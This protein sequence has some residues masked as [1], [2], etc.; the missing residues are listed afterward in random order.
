MIAIGTHFYPAD[1]DSE[2]RQ[3]RARAALLALDGAIP[4]NLQFT[5][6]G[7]RP[8]GF[9]TLPVLRQDSRTVT[10]A[11]GVRKP[12]VSE[13]FAA[14]ADAARAGGCRYFAY[15]NADIEV[16]QAALET[17]LSGDRDAY[18]F[19]RVDL[20]PASGAELGV[21]LFGLDMFAVDAG[22]WAREARRFRPYI[23]G[24][25]CWD[26]VYAALICAHGR[27]H[28]VNEKPGI[29]H[30]RHPM[31]WKD[32]PFAEH[33]GFLAAL[34]APYFSRWCR[35]AAGLDEARKAGVTVDRRRLAAE[36][37][38]EARLSAGETVR[39]AARQMR[40]RFRHARR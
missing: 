15:L 16:R 3:A 29:Y 11:G 21:E 4:I 5:D 27:G 2:R 13:M 17:V 7:Y 1:A 30:E 8:D 31:L 33:N 37:L 12:I 34:D 20:D 9:R 10:G 35:Y 19:S 39:H 25:A 6:E 23:A 24:E 40:A 22:W 28:V 38:A 36:T 14:L 18:A 32:G 26:N